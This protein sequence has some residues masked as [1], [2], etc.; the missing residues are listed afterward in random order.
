MA[1]SIDLTTLYWTTSGVMPG[2][3]EISRF[4]FS[5]RVEAAARAGFKGIG[6]W[7]TDLEHIQQSMPLRDMRKLLDDNGMCCIELEF[8]TDWFLDG[9]RKRESDSRKR[10]LLTA[11]E[12]LRASHVKIGDFYN[13]VCPLH[14]LVEAFAGLCKEAREYGATIGYEIM[15][16]AVIGNLEDALTVVRDSGARNG[17]IVLDISDVAFLGITCEQIRQ[18]PLPLLVS[19]ELN[20]GTRPGS[21]MEDPSRVRRFC[22]E[23][24]F[25]IKGFIRCLREMGYDGPWAVEV[26]SK[27]L[28]ILPLRE[29][30]E[31]A[32][33]TT[34]A[35]FDRASPT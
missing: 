32:F 21:P 20:D 5:E 3:G 19:V 4:G 15:P 31:R 11:S 22:G 2:D 30:N 35:Q 1:R 13:S 28:A 27:E 6:I 23:G 17:G 18:I 34:I 26:F 24:E 33:Q 7:H 25:D 16:G 29:L 10:R 8:L 9:G 12:A 14:R